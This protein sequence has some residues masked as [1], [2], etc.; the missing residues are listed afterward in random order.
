ME[1][2]IDIAGTVTRR[3]MHGQDRTE[4]RR[5][6][7][8][9]VKKMKQSRALGKHKEVYRFLMGI[10]KKDGVPYRLEEF[11][12]D[13]GLL[14]DPQGIHSAV[15]NFLPAGL[16]ERMRLRPLSVLR[17]PTGRSCKRMSFKKRYA[18]LGLSDDVTGRIHASLN[19]ELKA[20]A[21]SFA[22]EGARCPSREE[23]DASIAAA[24]QGSAPGP[25]GLSY[26]MIKAWPEHVRKIVYE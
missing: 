8:D 6:L 9:R 18:H 16:A 11:G 7:N 19:K 17:G 10:G 2:N 21:T 15:T 22:V 14:T 12:T 13:D 23:F 25:S 20:D 26:N 3:K 5:E 24:K 4:L 1:D